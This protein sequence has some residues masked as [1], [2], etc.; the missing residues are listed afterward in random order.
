MLVCHDAAPGML[1]KFDDFQKININMVVS[2]LNVKCIKV[3]A[4]P[5]ELLCDSDVFALK[6][7]FIKV[8][9]YIVIIIIIIIIIVTVIIVYSFIV[10]FF[11]C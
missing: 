10:C 3:V 2:T 6:L 4:L 9:V 11:T 1:K 7:V 8:R 5:Q